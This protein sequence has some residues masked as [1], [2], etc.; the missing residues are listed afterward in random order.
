MTTAAGPYPP[1]WLAPPT[2]VAPLA[3]DLAPL[4]FRVEGDLRAPLLRER[5]VILARRHEALRLS[6]PDLRGA[7]PE[8]VADA[9]FAAWVTLDGDVLDFARAMARAGYRKPGTPLWRVRHLQA[10]RDGAGP[11]TDHLLVGL[12]RAIGDAWSLH[13]VAEE[14]AALYGEGRGG[15]APALAPTPAR[16]SAVTRYRAARATRPDAREEREYWRRETS[17]MTFGRDPRVTRLDSPAADVARVDLSAAVARGI[18]ESAA[19]CRAT[20]FA[21]VF[22]AVHLVTRNWLDIPA[23]VLLVEVADRDDPAYDRAVAAV[24]EPRPLRVWSS[25]ADS[26]T[27]LIERVRDALLDVLDAALV[28]LAIDD[29]PTKSFTDQPDRLT[30]LVELDTTNAM[31]ARPGA[32][33]CLR[34]DA[35]ALT[36]G[37]PRADLHVITRQE[38][39]QPAV[40]LARNPLALSG[41]AAGRFATE[42]AA[43]L[44]DLGNSAQLPNER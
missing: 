24:A 26:G 32:A 17:L 41:L 35:E 20:V 15:P 30:V 11:P 29:T 6:Y 27:D 38:D 19:A 37:R 12:D 36:S 31:T 10:T 1:A 5:L 14:L 9:V 33:L 28:P 16:V 23:P 25:P 13:V 2:E 22:A 7:A 8:Q 40:Y 4:V 18:A 21:V 43:A 42:L 34:D 3:A 39:G 44:A